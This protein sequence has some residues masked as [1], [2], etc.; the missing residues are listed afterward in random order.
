M[1]VTGHRMGKRVYIDTT[2]GGDPG[3]LSFADDAVVDL[4]SLLLAHS[5][6]YDAT[7]MHLSFERLTLG[8]GCVVGPRS[9]LMPGLSIARNQTVA[10]EELIM[11][12]RK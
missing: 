8:A 5:G 4:W 9:M 10:A 1:Q 7:G 3:P 2:R 11:S 12:A 6:T